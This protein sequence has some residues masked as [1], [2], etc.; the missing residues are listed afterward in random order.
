[1][2]LSFCASC[3]APLVD[4]PGADSQ[5]EDAI[6]ALAS[7]I[8]LQTPDASICL[9]ALERLL[10]VVR[11]QYLILFLTFVRAAHYWTRV[12]AEL[13]FEEDIKELLATHEAL[14]ACILNDPEA[15][16]DV[17]SQS[18]LD[19]SLVLRQKADKSG[20]LLAAI[21]DSSADAIVSKSLDG[22]I[23]SWNGGAERLFGYTAEEAI[24]KH[25]SLIIPV[26]R[27][28]EEVTILERLRRG[29]RIE[30]FDTVRVRK[31]GTRLD[32][33]LTISPVRD[34]VG[35]IIRASKIA[36]DITQRKQIERELRESQERFRELAAA[37]ET[38]VQ[39]RTQELERRNAEIL[40]QSD[41]LRALTGRLLQV[42]D[43]ER[44]HMARELHDSAGQTLTALGMKLS[45]FAQSAK[46]DPA[47]IAKDVEDAEKLVD[48][49][50]RE[51]RTTSYLLHPP[52]LD[53]S[54]L[55]SALHWYVEG[56]EKRSGLDIELRI[57][58]DF[59]RLSRE[60]EL[61]LFRLVQESLTNIHRQSGSKTALI[62]IER[63]G[64]NVYVEVKDQGKGI[65]SDRLAEIQS[66]G[67]GV[68]IRG[69]IERV[70]QFHGELRI[71]SD[72]SGTKIC[73]TLPT[74]T[75]ST[76]EQGRF[77]QAA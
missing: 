76:T 56:L 4:M 14:A 38:Q 70:H 29:E 36:R 32:I 58:E 11:L 53:E 30:H 50:T 66:Q 7:H 67:T 63:T 26:E 37:L 43:G 48:Q 69:M 77:N 23:S 75:R 15:G 51:I 19:E 61:L 44:R 20:A 2:Q 65:S 3:P 8:F 9:D 73:A 16:S 39:L 54:G 18:L 1:M 74:K 72:G 27:H 49:L 42:Q 34:A 52:L 40:R 10:G 47:Q 41:Q 33:S 57:S 31:D 6:F 71:E 59:G 68:G 13:E 21:V 55:R 12:H 24:G 35:R 64:D 45:Q 46:Q 25:I 60:M 28:H 5:V 22:V 17:V 62:R